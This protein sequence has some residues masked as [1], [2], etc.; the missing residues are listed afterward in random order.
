MEVERP[1]YSMFYQA[2]THAHSLPTVTRSRMLRIILIMAISAVISFCPYFFNG[3]K[4]KHLLRYKQIIY[5]FFAM[6]CY[7]LS[8]RNVHVSSKRVLVATQSRTDNLAT[9]VIGQWRK[10]GV[11]G[12]GEARV[13]ALE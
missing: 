8:E 10:H 5:Y 3:C 6:F 12:V 13:L 1:C 7:N 11:L 9:H 4:G 2:C